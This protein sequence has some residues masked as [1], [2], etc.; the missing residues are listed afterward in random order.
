M[1]NKHWKFNSVES[2]KSDLVHK[3]GNYCHYITQRKHTVSGKTGTKQVHLEN[4][5]KKYARWLVKNR[6]SITRWRH[7]TSVSCWHNDGASKENLHFYDQSKQVV[8]L[9]FHSGVFKRN[10]YLIMFF[11]FL[12]SFRISCSL[13]LSL[14]S[15]SW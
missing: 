8:F 5:P 7:R 12:S 2:P 1:H 15:H 13:K 4:S 6:A 10:R 11:V 14:I 9:F 3:S